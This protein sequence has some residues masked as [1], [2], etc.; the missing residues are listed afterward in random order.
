[1]IRSSDIFVLSVILVSTPI[2]N[3]IDHVKENFSLARVSTSYTYS[4]FKAL[5]LASRDLLSE[6]PNLFAQSFPA[7]LHIPSFPLRLHASHINPERTILFDE[8]FPS[9]RLDIDLQAPKAVAIEIRTM[10]IDF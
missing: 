10:N 3:G 1:M 2:S 7:Y 8:N 5:W 9:Q 4:L 6:N